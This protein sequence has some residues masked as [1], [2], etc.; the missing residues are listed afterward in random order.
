MSGKLTEGSIVTWSSLVACTKFLLRS[1]VWSE[2][3]PS[4]SESSQNT[5]QNPFPNKCQT[6]YLYQHFVQDWKAHCQLYLK[7]SHKFLGF[8]LNCR[9]DHSTFLT[10]RAKLGSEHFCSPPVSVRLPPGGLAAEGPVVWL[11]FV[12]ATLDNLCRAGAAQHFP[13]SRC[14]YPKMN[15]CC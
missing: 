8:L 2:D 10:A 7:L 15:G 6:Q 13:C 4:L 11:C 5:K 12:R 1:L 9:K 14:L 3:N